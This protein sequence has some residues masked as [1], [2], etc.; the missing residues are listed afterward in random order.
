ML[1]AIEVQSVYSSKNSENVMEI[2]NKM[3]TQINILKCLNGRC[4]FTL[5]DHSE[6]PHLNPCFIH[7]FK[8]LLKMFH[9]SSERIFQFYRLM[10]TL[11]A[12]QRLAEP[13]CNHVSRCTLVPP[14]PL[15]T[16]TFHCCY[17]SNL[18]AA[19][20][21][22]F[23]AVDEW[24]NSSTSK[25]DAHTSRSTYRPPFVHRLHLTS[26][27]CRQ[28]GHPKT[29]VDSERTTSASPEIPLNAVLRS[30]LIQFNLHS[31]L[32][33]CAPNASMPHMTV[34]RSVTHKKFT[35]VTHTLIP[36]LAPVTPNDSH[37]YRV[38]PSAR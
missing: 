15:I 18:P 8:I 11:Q 16:D 26:A 6:N 2:M 23:S 1:N 12:V 33:Q 31:H 19:T 9:I 7:L 34:E 13:P 10:D 30:L 4:Q 22:L 17:Q 25:S 37:D 24:T 29:A 21:S 14:T 36:T 28:T 35:S 20:L 27:F 5:C 3:G 38:E 32:S